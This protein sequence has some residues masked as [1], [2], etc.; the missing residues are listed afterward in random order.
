M[1]D[2]KKKEKKDEK[3]S[4]KSVD[5]ARQYGTHGA[6]KIVQDKNSGKLNFKGKDS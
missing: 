6:G 4:K 1:E 5:E 3:K 2:K